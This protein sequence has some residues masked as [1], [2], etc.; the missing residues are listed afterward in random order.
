MLGEVGD[1]VSAFLFFPFPRGDF[2]IHSH[3][4]ASYQ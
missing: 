3:C 1:G 4:I 2:G